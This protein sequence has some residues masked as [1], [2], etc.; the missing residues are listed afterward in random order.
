MHLGFLN[1]T[2]SLSETKKI[3]HKQEQLA[4]ETPK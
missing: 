2:T 4:M 3:I 1:S